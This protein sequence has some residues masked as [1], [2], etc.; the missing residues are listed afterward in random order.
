LRASGALAASLAA[1]VPAVPSE[2]SSTSSAFSGKRLGTIFNNDIN[3]IL[4]ASSGGNITPE[5]YQ[6]A[7]YAILDLKPGVLAQNVGMPDPVLYPSS[8]ATSFDRHLEEAS[9]SLSPVEGTPEIARRQADAMRRLRE[10]GADPFT[11][12]IAACRKRGVLILASYRMNA[13]DFYQSTMLMSDFERGH[14]EWRIPGANCA[15]PAVPEVYAHRMEIFR[16]VAE[17]YDIDGIEF[18]FRRW[19]HMVSDPLKNHTVLTRMVRETRRMLEDTA[20]KKGRRELI[21][22]AR[23]GPSLETDPAP[24]VYPGIF[25]PEKPTNASCKDLG[26]DVKTWI[27]EG[28]VDALCPSLFLDGLPSLPKTREFLALARGTKIGIYTTLWSWPLWGHGICERSVSLEKK[29]EQALA[30]YKDELCTTALRMYEEGA[31]GIST[32]NWYSH[33]RNAKLPNLEPDTS[34]QA[35]AGTDAVQ[36]YIYPLLK[37]PAAI[38]DYR[39]SPW[40]APATS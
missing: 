9:K 11:L 18:D 15:D 36:T 32:F 14:P 30:L 2:K 37:D 16:E 25:Y 7:V 31:D 26:L 29:D 21:L 6:R 13:E 8:V 4:A 35:G 40:A 3:N 19:Y 27:A 10:L 23:V 12:T 39:E 24:F 1:A 34:S 5:E 28:L 17:R 38:R 20:R 33:L 22:E